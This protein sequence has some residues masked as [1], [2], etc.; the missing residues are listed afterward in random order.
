VKPENIF[1]AR[2]SSGG[3][4]PKLLDF[5]V[6]KAREEDV[7]ATS[8]GQ[9]LGTPAYM[10]PEQA[11]GETDIDHRTDLWSL[12][13][14]LYEMLSGKHPFHAPNYQALLPRIAEAPHA[15]LDPEI[16]ASLRRIVDRCL[17]KDRADRFQTADAL[18]EA[19]EAALSGI[20]H[21]DSDGG[22]LVERRAG[23]SIAPGPMRAPHGTLSPSIHPVHAPVRGRTLLGAAVAA[24]AVVVIAALAFQS[25][26]RGATPSAAAGAVESAAA[27][28]PSIAPPATV[29]PTAAPPIV[30]ELP[31]VADPPE[32]P[33]AS[34]AS[35]KVSPPRSGSPRRPHPITRVNTAGF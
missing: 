12:G 25:L 2:G 16:P 7:Y 8:S 14:V 24:A 13:V 33:P 4:V 32:P 1:L 18:G 34:A 21:R 26:R 9:L 35:A 10:S 11:L 22:L 29:A 5:G 6:S 3:I 27:A 31:E 23:A 28:S 30:I 17:A 20:E 19:L 15:P